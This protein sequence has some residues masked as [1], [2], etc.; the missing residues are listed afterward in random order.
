MA[1]VYPMG[2][3]FSV[4]MVTILS[5]YGRFQGR[6]MTEAMAKGRRRKTRNGNDERS[7]PSEVRRVAD[8]R[9]DVRLLPEERVRWFRFLPIVL[10]SS[11]GGRRYTTGGCMK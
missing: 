9:S 6:S 10:H 3:L 4:A 2:E 8:L 1:L 7:D 11:K 5:D